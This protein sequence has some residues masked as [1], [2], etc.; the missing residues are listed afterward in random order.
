MKKYTLR[1]LTSIN[2][3]TIIFI[4]LWWFL[5]KI[6][7]GNDPL[8]WAIYF[9][10]VLTIINA[11]LIILYINK[12]TDNYSCIKKLNKVYIILSIIFFII[13]WFVL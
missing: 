8:L 13:L 3:L 5:W 6:E 7:V 11:T 12:F 4:Y 2:Y 9:L 1:I 10:Y